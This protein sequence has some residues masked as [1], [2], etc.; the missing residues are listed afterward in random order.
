MALGSQLVPQHLVLYRGTLLGLTHPWQPRE[1][2]L[3]AL[4]LMSMQLIL[5]SWQLHQQWLRSVGTPEPTFPRPH[6]KSPR[7]V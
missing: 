5:Q 7:Y 1:A 3:Y 2:R 4:T 6:W